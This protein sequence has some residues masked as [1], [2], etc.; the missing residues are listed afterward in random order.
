MRQGRNGRAGSAPTIDANHHAHGL[1][2][3]SPLMLIVACIVLSIATFIFTQIQIANTE[4]SVYALLQVGTTIA[5]GMTGAQVQQFLNGNV[6][7]YQG[8]ADVIGWGVQIALFMLSFPPDS[9]LLS[10]HRR[11]NDDT[12]TSL[13]QS[14]M[15]QEKWR[16]LISKGLIVGDILTDFW[17]VVGGYSLVTMH[18]IVPNVSGAVI[19]VVVVGIL[20]PTCICFITIYGFKYLLVFLEALIEKVTH[21]AA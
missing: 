10:L 15:S 3:Q 2:A 4:Q 20:F 17:H 18:G 5:P 21:A 14:A 11:F 1:I 13:T 12:S 7:Y 9:A 8:I 6:D 16:L 19:G